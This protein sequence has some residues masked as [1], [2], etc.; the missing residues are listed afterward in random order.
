MSIETRLVRALVTRW[1]MTTESAKRPTAQPDQI[2]P[3]SASGSGAL[4]TAS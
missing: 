4:R 2:I 1:Q 3:E